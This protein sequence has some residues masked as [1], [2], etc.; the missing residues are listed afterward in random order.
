MLLFALSNRSHVDKSWELISQRTPATVRL[1]RCPRTNQFQLGNLRSTR[2][3][4]DWALS[5]ER[6]QQYSDFTDGSATFIVVYI[7][8]KCFNDQLI[9]NNVSLLLCTVLIMYLSLPNY[10]CIL[11]FYFFVLFREFTYLITFTSLYFIITSPVGAVAK[12]CHEYVCVCVCVCV[13]LESPPFYKISAWARAARRKLIDPESQI[14][15]LLIIIDSKVLWYSRL[16]VL[17][18]N[19]TL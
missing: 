16:W 8:N 4:A 1:S 17:N 19:I 3:S 10:Y 5:Y 9:R 6:C 13:C 14:T 2:H 7:I 11:L 12:Y 18:E 15:T